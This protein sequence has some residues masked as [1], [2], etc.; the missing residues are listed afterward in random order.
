VA[1]TYGGDFTWR[2]EFPP[3]EIGRWRVRWRHELWGPEETGPWSVFDV[4]AGDVANARREVRALT[5]RAEAL[6]RSG[7]AAERELEAF[8]RLERGAMQ[9]LTPDEFRGDVGRELLRELG[10]A[11]EA[12]W[13]REV[14]GEIPMESHE[15]RREAGERRFEHPIP[16]NDEHFRD[17]IY[18][19]RSGLIRDLPGA[20]AEWAR[21]LAA[22]LRRAMRLRA[23][24]PSR[25]RSTGPGEGRAR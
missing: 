8:L 1:G 14:P 7:P 2:V 24:P 23:D 13:G 11:R 6:P 3:D 15:L 20:V 9:G 12:L 5:R 4:V 16:R 21:G 22:R 18:R 25:S 19:S 17:E 10:E